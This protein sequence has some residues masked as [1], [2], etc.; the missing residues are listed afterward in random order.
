VNTSFDEIAGQLSPDGRWLAYASNESGCY[1]IHLRSFPEPRGEW[2]ILTAGGTQPRWRRD[3]QELFYVASDTRMMAAPIRPASAERTVETGALLALFPTR[4]ASTGTSGGCILRYGV[5]REGAICRATEPK[6]K[7]SFL[8]PPHPK[9]DL[10]ARTPEQ[11]SP[12]RA[13]LTGSHER[14]HSAAKTTLR[15]DGK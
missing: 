15:R 1:E 8:P 9:T 5:R 12:V 13:S 4:L 14:M 11:A 7:L 3:G 10:R 6:I 2:Q